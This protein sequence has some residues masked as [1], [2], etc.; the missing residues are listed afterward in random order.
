[1]LMDIEGRPALWYL[2]DRMKDASGI[3]VRAVCTSTAEEDAR[4]EAFATSNG[5]ASFRGDENDV[6]RR[7]LGAAER[8]EADFFVNVDG[9]D[10]FCSVEN[11][12]KIIDRHLESGADYVGCADLPFGGAPI[13]VRVVALRK[14]CALK[15]ETDTQGWGK[16]FTQ[17]G[18]F[19]VET[20]AAEGPLRRPEYRMTLDYPEDLEFFRQTIRALDP[21]HERRLA[22]GEVVAYL[23]AHPEV[24]AI[25][26][27]VNT[28]YWERFHKEHGS[29][30]IRNGEEI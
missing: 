1:M 26:Q 24:A 20:L 11:V 30:S 9:D 28:Q 27:K 4:I 6:L 10:L 19:Q 29:F 5:W 12:R 18:L 14:V 17:S 25:S 21:T 8:F 3:D 2:L 16:Y 23:D 13:G 15:G 22:L 7:Y